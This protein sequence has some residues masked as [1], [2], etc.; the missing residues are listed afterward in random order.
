MKFR[1]SLRKIVTETF[2]ITKTEYSR[3]FFERQPD[4]CTEF[5]VIGRNFLIA[6]WRSKTKASLCSRRQRKSETRGC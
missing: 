3:I 4:F 5:A 1:F 2:Q 6:G